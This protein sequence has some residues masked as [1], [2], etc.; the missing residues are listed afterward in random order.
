MQDDPQASCVSASFA[1]KRAS[2]ASLPSDNVHLQ[3]G[4]LVLNIDDGDEAS[5]GGSLQHCLS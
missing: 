5:G 3:P 4:G 1:M 2:L